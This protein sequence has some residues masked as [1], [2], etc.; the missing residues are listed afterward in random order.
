KPSLSE[1]GD[2]SHL[3]LLL[4]PPWKM[5]WVSHVRIQ[6]FRTLLSTSL[7]HLITLDL[8]N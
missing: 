4:P 5:A 7:A 6:T 3:P 2:L 8:V 1:A